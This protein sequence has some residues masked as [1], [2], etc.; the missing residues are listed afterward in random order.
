MIPS[1]IGT[2][3]RPGTDRVGIAAVVVRETALVA[4]PL[5]NLKTRPLACALLVAE[6]MLDESTGEAAAVLAT[7][8][9]AAEFASRF[10]RENAGRWQ[11]PRAYLSLAVP[12]ALRCAVRTVSEDLGDDAPDV[13]VTMLA[14]AIGAA[15]AA[16]GLDDDYDVSERRW[17]TAC[18]LVGVQRRRFTDE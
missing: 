17:E 18:N 4:L 3:H 14:N 13:L 12:Q 10:L 5:V 9:D 8:P 6:H 15:R 7:Q 16:C 1:V 11:D 2:G